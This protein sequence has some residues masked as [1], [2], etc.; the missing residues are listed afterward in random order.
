MSLV[1]R[2]VLSQCAAW[3]AGAAWGLLLVVV[4]GLALLLVH[5]QHIPSI[6]HG[7]MEAGMEQ[8]S[9]VAVLSSLTSQSAT[10][11]GVGL[12][13]LLTIVMGSSLSGIAIAM[14]RQAR[15]FGDRSFAAS[16]GLAGGTA[17]LVCSGGLT[18]RL[19]I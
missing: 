10:V 18:I 15:R 4:G 12:G 11:I 7:T 9:Q 5:L 6:S 13:L 3:C 8:A 16:A 1:D 19:L 17:Y 2:A 14:A